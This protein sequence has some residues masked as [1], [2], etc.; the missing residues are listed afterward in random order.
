MVHSEDRTNRRSLGSRIPLLASPLAA[1]Y[2]GT[3]ATTGTIAAYNALHGEID[4]MFPILA[5]A[6]LFSLASS[7]YFGRRAERNKRQSP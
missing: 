2:L 3:S 1:S 7:Y 5:G 6:S 4:Y